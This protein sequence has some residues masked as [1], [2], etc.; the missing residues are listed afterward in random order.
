MKPH[1]FFQTGRGIVPAESPDFVEEGFDD[2]LASQVDKT[3]L[4]FGVYGGQAFAE[5]HKL[6]ERRR[7]ASGILRF[8]SNGDGREYQSQHDTAHQ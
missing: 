6:F 2:P 7:A 4:P 5:I 8:G 1:R 3:P